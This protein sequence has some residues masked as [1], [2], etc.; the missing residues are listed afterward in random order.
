[1]L[2][3]YDDGTFYMRTD[4]GGY[5]TFFGFLR[6]TFFG[7]CIVHCRILG[8][9]VLVVYCINRNFMNDEI[10]F[11]NDFA[12][13]GS[14]D[15]SGYCTHAL[16]HCGEMYFR[17][18]GKSFRVVA[19]DCIIFIHNELVTEIETSADFCVTV[20]YITYSF[21]YRNTPRNNYDINGKLTLIQNPVMPLNAM[22]QQT[23]LMDVCLIRK[24][25]ECETHHFYNELIGCFTE[26]FI[27]DL[28]D[29]H[30]QQYGYSSVSKQSA[31]I[32]N[33]FIELLRAGEYQAHRDVAYYASK[34]CITPKYLTEIS[35][36]VSGFSASFWIDRFTISEITRLLSDKTLTL[37]EISARMNFSSVS[38]FC[39]YVSRVLKITPSEYRSNRLEK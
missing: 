1:M 37:K 23:F 29:F 35:K 18:G 9:F 20:V 27:L 2:Q 21:L 22:G 15:M 7:L 16:C 11:A 3:S 28:Y 24:R 30:A 31:G 32:L 26:A 12:A 8:I 14:K 34:L 39:R 19:G 6:L 4:F 5:F 25:L 13:L 17:M 33:H 36:K 38:Y 10:I